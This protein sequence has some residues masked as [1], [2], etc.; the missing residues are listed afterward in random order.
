MALSESSAA[1]LIT[2]A[3]LTL[4]AP[5]PEDLHT[6]VTLHADPAVNRFCACAGPHTPEAMRAQLQDWLAHW[7]AHG[8]GHWAI[9][10]R[11][12]P[13]TLIGFGGLMHR[14]VG[15][16]AGLYLYY[17]IQ[18]QA[19]GR[20]LAS[21]MVRQALELA[22]DELGEPSVLAAVLPTNAPTRRTL[23]GQGLRLKGALS[24]A[25]GQTASLLYELT[26]S[27]WASLPR[28][29]PEAVPFGA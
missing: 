7:E 19:W 25:P 10:E 3:R 20:G 23:E 17:R 4:R 6:L 29:E 27:R 18:P 2:T 14:S 26:A 13:G 11:S 1:A 15:G 8:F 12:D 21:E 22:F 24:D 5:R 16:H 9:A 28:H